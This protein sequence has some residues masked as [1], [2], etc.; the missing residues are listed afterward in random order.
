M[1]DTPRLLK[2][3]GVGLYESRI[4]AMIRA[5]EEFSGKCFDEKVFLDYIRDKEESQ[6][7]GMKDHT[8]NI[9]IL[10]QEPTTASARSWKKEMRNVAF[11][12]TCT[13]LGR[14]IFCDESE[15]LKSYARA[16]FPSSLYADGTGI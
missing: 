10:G 7:A 1:L 3:V 2:E 5:Y 9:G 15:V 8:V 4:R 11:D 13:G 14:K 16:C 12:L 6:Q